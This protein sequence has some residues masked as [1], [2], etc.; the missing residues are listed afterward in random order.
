MITIMKRGG[1]VT[2]LA[3]ASV[4]LSRLHSG[5]LQTTIGRKPLGT[6]ACFRTQPPFNFILPQIQ[7]VDIE[8]NELISI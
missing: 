4:E 7:R 6:C 8:V 5:A 1:Q 2:Y 3:V